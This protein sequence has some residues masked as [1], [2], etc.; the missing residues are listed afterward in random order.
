MAPNLLAR[1]FTAE[2]PEQVWLADISYIPTKPELWIR[3][4]GVPEEPRL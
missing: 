1:N 4:E 3:V 2:R